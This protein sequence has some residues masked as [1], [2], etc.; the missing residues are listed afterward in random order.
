MAR[1]EARL[2]AAAGDPAAAIALLARAVEQSS[3]EADSPFGLA[4]LEHDYG[5]LLLAARRRRSAIRWLRSAHDRY[6]DLGAQPFAQRCMRQLTDSGVRSPGA[7]GGTE[8]PGAETADRSLAALTPQEHGIAELAAQ[9]MT[10][11]QIARVQFVSAKTV[12]YHLGNIFAKLGIASR[13]QLRAALESSALE[14]SADVRS[15]R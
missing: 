13:R 6:V 1:L 3:P 10:N 5:R 15:P 2:A 4:E 11:Q 12:E 8:E 9:G 7:A 14:I